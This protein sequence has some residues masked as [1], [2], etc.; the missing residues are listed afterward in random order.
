MLMALL[1]K[2]LLY[3]FPALAPAN[4]WLYRS[5]IQRD[6]DNGTPLRFQLFKFITGNELNLFPNAANLCIVHSRRIVC[7][8][9]STQFSGGA[10][11]PRGRLYRL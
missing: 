11:T 7:R 2:P 3:F 4:F 5:I 10:S 1:I 9:V 8:D 6:F